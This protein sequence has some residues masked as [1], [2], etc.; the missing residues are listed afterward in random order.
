MIRET[1][2]DQ[3]AM[4]AKGG[5]PEKGRLRGTEAEATP[6]S[7]PPGFGRSVRGGESDRAVLGCGSF[8][9]GSKQASPVDPQLQQLH[10]MIQEKFLQ[11]KMTAY[12]LQKKPGAESEANTSDESLRSLQ[13]CGPYDLHRQNLKR[14]KT[15]PGAQL[16]RSI[17][18]DRSVFRLDSS[19]ARGDL[20]PQPGSPARLEAGPARE[21][22]AKGFHELIHRLTCKQDFTQMAHKFTRK[23]PAS[24]KSLIAFPKNESTS[25][26][27][28]SSSRQAN[29]RVCAG[30][31]VSALKTQEQAVSPPE[32]RLFLQ[33]PNRAEPGRASNSF[34][35]KLESSLRRA[36]FSSH[37]HTKDDRLLS[38]SIG[39]SFGKQPPR[40]EPAPPKPLEEYSLPRRK[41]QTLNVKSALKAKPVSDL[42]VA[43]AKSALRMLESHKKGFGPA[44]IG[45]VESTSPLRL[46]ARA[47][48]PGYAAKAASRE[49]LTLGSRPLTER[50]YPNARS[51]SN[52]KRI[53]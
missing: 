9:F 44:A 17:V 52:T 21:A 36:H 12:R 53:T 33:Q 18:G 4:V 6:A 31:F 48:Q 20:Q 28:F 26:I 25:R 16:Q 49:Y 10:A 3:E 34:K 11:S 30:G 2:N 45:K 22:K 23:N 8:Q 27:A 35:A 13:G 43:L 29:L 15:E 38:S 39:A 24:L 50:H 5:A 37:L 40:R 41:E 14:G 46:T 51:T 7:S 1:G 42:F 19:T 47:K 32:Q